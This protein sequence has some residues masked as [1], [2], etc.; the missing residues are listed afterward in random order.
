MFVRS[1]RVAAIVAALA[2]AA[3]GCAVPGG[4]ASGAAAS[5]AS[6]PQAGHAA[7]TPGHSA[8]AGPAPSRSSIPAPA[9]PGGQAGWTERVLLP[10]H[11][12]EAIAQQVAD[13]LTGELFALVQAGQASSGTWRLRS[14]DLR[15]GQV[16]QGPAFD[17]SNLVLAGGYLW[18][19][20]TAGRAA[21]PV[22]SQVM[23]ATLTLVRSFDLAAGAAPQGRPGP[24]VAAGPAG[25]VWLGAD[26]T[27]LRV[28]LSAGQTLARATLPAGLAVD[29]LSA[30]T[31]HGILY[32]GATRLVHG[33]PEG[34]GAIFEYSA[35]TGAQ[36]AADAGGL[37]RYSVAGPALT[38]VPG[39]VWVS[40][41]T[42]ML[43]ITYHLGSAGLRMIAPPGPGVALSPP[44]IFHWPMNAATAYGGGTLW[45]TNDRGVLAC[46]DPQAGTVLASERL[47]QS[48]LL[49][50]FAG[51][52]QAAHVILA[53]GER[54]LVQITPPSR[55]WS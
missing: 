36:L 20:G 34:G 42:G 15:T 16:R 21:L 40:F 3:A 25:S 35:R 53:L 44:G 18:V 54:G 22:I 28:G 7:A 23:P 17:V 50:Q 51:V 10:E 13:P 49:S 45:L 14:T 12:S 29:S 27:L 30:D 4:G 19:Y 39:G 37:V 33:E 43:G 32:A 55:C 24:A 47:S 26:R 2:L 52:D 48:R 31:E 38:A 9:Q 11:G 1:Y 5:P 8:P 41:R 6:G 46:L